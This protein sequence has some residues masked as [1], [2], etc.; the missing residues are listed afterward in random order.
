MAPTHPNLEVS[1][2]GNLLAM[3]GKL[4]LCPRQHDCGLS[5]AWLCRGATRGEGAQVLTCSSLVAGCVTLSDERDVSHRLRVL[6]YICC[7]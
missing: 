7:D 6:S 1:V 5:Y 2:G 3:G 4:G